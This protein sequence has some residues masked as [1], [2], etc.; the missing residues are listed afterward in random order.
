LTREVEQQ[1]ERL[2][3][4]KAEFERLME[5]AGRVVMKWAPLE[6]VLRIKL[7][8]EGYEKNVVENTVKTR[9]SDFERLQRI[10]QDRLRPKLDPDEDFRQRI[11]NPATRKDAIQYFLKDNVNKKHYL[12]ET[13]ALIFEELD[14]RR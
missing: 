13:I 2:Q 5:Q 12:V 4:A 8:A 1:W 11:L 10:V 3:K 7:Q 9:R 14:K 6:K